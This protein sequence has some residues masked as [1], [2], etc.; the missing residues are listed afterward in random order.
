MKNIVVM[1]SGGGTNLQ[2]LIDAKNNGEIP[3]GEISLVISSREEAYALKRAEEAGIKTCVYKRS[4][5]N[6][7]HEYSKALRDVLNDAHAD[8]VVFAGFLTIVGEELTGAFE[9]KIINIHPSLIPSFCGEGYWGLHVHEAVLKYGVKLTGATVHFVNEKCDAGPIILQQS[10]YVN[11]NDTP[12]SLQQRVMREC[13]WVLLPKAVSLF[14]DDKIKI[15]GN[16]TI[17]END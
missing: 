1:V 11:D 14:C 5:Y 13:E 10:I 6:D 12:E 4:S 15:I 17:I 16:R 3:N 2:A 9:N 8:L 7:V